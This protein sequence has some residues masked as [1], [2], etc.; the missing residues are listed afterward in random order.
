MTS[1]QGSL[2]LLDILNIISFAMQ[3]VN[4]SEKMRQA[5]SDDLMSELQRQNKAY[6]EK[7]LLNQEKILAKLAELAD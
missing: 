4:Y 1:E 7:I 6:L 5:S 3:A 2:E